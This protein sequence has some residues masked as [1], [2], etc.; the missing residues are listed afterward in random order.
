MLGELVAW[1]TLKGATYGAFVLYLLAL[2]WYGYDHAYG[3]QALAFVGLLASM[4]AVFW[5][6]LRIPNPFEWR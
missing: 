1:L 6:N 4:C 3:G 5:I 2:G